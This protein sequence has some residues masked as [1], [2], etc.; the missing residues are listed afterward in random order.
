MHKQGWL[1]AGAL[2][3]VL[4]KPGALAAEPLKWMSEARDGR[5]EARRGGT[6]MFAWQSTPLA[7]PAGGD[8][9]KGSAFLHPLCT[10][11]GFQWT[12]SQPP[13]HLHHFGLWWPWKFI[14]VGGARYNCWEIQ[15]GQGGQVA[16]SVRPLAGGPD[17]LEWEFQND[18]VIHQPGEPSLTAIHETA[19]VGLALSGADA[20]VIDVALRQQAAAPPVKILQ[21]LYSGFSWRGP[22]SWNKDNSRITTS[23]GH[24]RDDANGTPA[25]WVVCSGPT[26]HGQASVL[27]MSAAVDLAGAPEKLRV[28]DSTAQNGKPFVNFNPGTEQALPLDELHPAVAKRKYRVVAAARLLDAAAAEA[29][30]RQWLGK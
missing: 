18:V 13:D 1:V 22:G 12:D 6:L 5:V 27:L 11:S 15:Q 20:V 4:A 24:G 23:E 30:W 16:R 10:P 9:F 8:Q 26:P 14:E 29:A 25:R 7:N 28:W 21:H 2:A 19:R 3:A 17:Q